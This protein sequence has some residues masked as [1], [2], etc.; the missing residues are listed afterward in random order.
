MHV[1]VCVCVCVGV[2]LFLFCLGFGFIL[3]AGF[4]VSFCS[5]GQYG[6][7]RQN[8]YTTPACNILTH[9]L[10]VTVGAGMPP[11]TRHWKRALPPGRIVCCSCGKTSIIGAWRPGSTK[12]I[13]HFKD[14]NMSVA[15]PIIWK[16]H[17]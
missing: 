9:L 17:V 7:D 12:H 5:G 2:W 13:V 16:K 6:D 10:Q 1:C 3:G 11:V 8:R 15:Q 14:S 4:G